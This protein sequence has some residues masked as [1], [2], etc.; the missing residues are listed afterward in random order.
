MLKVLNIL[1]T[2]ARGP[3]RRTFLSQAYY[4]NEVWNNRLNS[5]ILQKINH[6]ELYYE[7][8]QRFQ[9]N[10]I[11]SA[12]DVDI[13]ANS[14]KDDIYLD[15]LM[16][17]AHKLRLSADTSNTLES[18]S[19]AVIRCLLNYD[20]KDELLNALDDRLNYGLFLDNYTANILMDYFYKAKD[21]VSGSRVASQLMLQEEM[22][23]P[24]SSSLSI[25]HC[26][27]FL[28]NPVGWPEMPKPEE[29][30]EEVKVRVKYLRNPYD[31]NHFDLRDPIRIVGKTLMEATIEKN[32]DLEKSLYILGISLFDPEQAKNVVKGD[33]K[34]YK[35]ILNLLPEDNEMKATLE[36]L[37]LIPGELKT[38]LESKV[39]SCERDVGEKDVAVQCETYSKWEQNRLDALKRQEERYNIA[40]RIENIETS[41]KNLKLREER[42]WFFENEEQIEL[43]IDAKKIY[44]PKR[45]FGKMKKPRTAD[46][47]YVPPEIN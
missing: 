1:K 22:N 43:D 45:W 47:A 6:D 19:H 26:Y 9:K 2:T 23:H 17:L 4:C 7:L 12:V 34:I 11:I 35:E 15:E 32:D 40:N 16:D 10:G 41:Q 13:F 30:E 8:E 24:L 33:E 20:K 21:F 5:T 3:Q 25:F 31:D 37:T 46:K 14:V 39:K 38:L 29:P 44:Y 18:T 42:L 28:L 27:N 36:K